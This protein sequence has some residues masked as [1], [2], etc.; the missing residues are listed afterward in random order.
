MLAKMLYSGSVRM[1]ES[2]NKIAVYTC[3][4]G[5]YDDVK[6]FPAV[7]EKGIDYFLF[8]NNQTITSSFWQIVPI[9][10]EGLDNV[11]LARKIKVLG[12]QILDAYD[13]TVWLDGASYPRVPVSQ[14]INEC[15]DLTRYS[16]IGFKHHARDC[17]YDEA[18]ECV[19]VDKDNCQIIVEQ[20]QHYQKQGYPRHQGLIESTIMVRRTH[21]ALLQQTMELWFKEIC[22]YSRRDQLSFNYVA[23]QTGLSFNLLDMNV[24][25]NTYFGWEK[26]LTGRVHEHLDRYRVLC[27]DDAHFV[28]DGYVEGRYAHFQD[29]YRLEFDLPIDCSQFK[30]EFARHAGI[31]YNNFQIECAGLEHTDIVNHHGYYGAELFDKGIPTLFCYGCFEVGTHVVI[32]LDMRVLSDD[33][34]LAIMIR[35]GDDVRLLSNGLQHEREQNHS[36]LGKIKRRLIHR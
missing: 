3:I 16:L 4:T 30:V 35:L 5:D 18:V 28:L 8:T 17:A 2:V 15:C 24:F 31:E 19:L 10:N 20:M 33:E 9:E 22:T 13:I 32:S 27:N 1:G 11:R 26:H 6:E 14:F 34:L 25:D 23:A 29:T 21:D 12:H 36:Y 7:R